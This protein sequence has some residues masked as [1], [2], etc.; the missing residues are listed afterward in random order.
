M[1]ASHNYISI[2]ASERGIIK[3]LVKIER[4]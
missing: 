3:E 1:K 4:R 2:I